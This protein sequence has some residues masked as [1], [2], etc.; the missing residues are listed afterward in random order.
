MKVTFVQSGGV[1]GLVKGCDLD[2]A[3]LPKEA[4][5]ELERL[6]RASNLPKSGQYL[7]DTAR[8]LFTY[9]ITLDDGKAKTAVVLD[10]ST[11]PATAKPL[12]AFVKKHAKPRKP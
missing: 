5:E 11:V 7:S 1:A 12:V 3:T 9:E 10:D 4:G 2:T 6:A 8:D